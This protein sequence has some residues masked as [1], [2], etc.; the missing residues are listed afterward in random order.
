MNQLTQMF[1]CLILSP[2]CVIVYWLAVN[3]DD[4][5]NE[6]AFGAQEPRLL[7][8]EGFGCLFHIKHVFR[9]TLP[10]LQLTNLN[11]IERL[12]GLQ[13][14]ILVVHSLKV[15]SSLKPLV[16]CWAPWQ[17]TEQR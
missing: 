14:A 9:Q 16:D 6:R 12:T 11:Q 4:H 3:K 17:S 13:S 8:N 15:N 1:V 10:Y 7:V 2:S 5:P